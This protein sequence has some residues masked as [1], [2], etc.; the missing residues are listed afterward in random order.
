MVRGRRTSVLSFPL[1]IVT[2]SYDP[3]LKGKITG[4][5]ILSP[6]CSPSLP[7]DV[8]WYSNVS[9]KGAPA[10]M[11]RVVSVWKLPSPITPKKPYRQGGG[12][13]LLSLHDIHMMLLEMTIQV[14]NDPTKRVM[15]C[16][17]PPRNMQGQPPTEHDMEQL[18]ELSKSLQRLVTDN[19]D[20]VSYGECYYPAHCRVHSGAGCCYT[21]LLP[22][23]QR[24]W[25]GTRRQAHSHRHQGGWRS[26]TRSDSR[27]RRTSGTSS[28]RC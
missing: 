14:M 11:L 12:F 25:R 15:P 3:A 6:I 17:E 20:P 4:L 5:V 21:I 16:E 9:P 7:S 10:V 13:S 24:W 26:L 18:V 2:L 1:H 27:G 8:G 23:E 22:P 19:V 28:L